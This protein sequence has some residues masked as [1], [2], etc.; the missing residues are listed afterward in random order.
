MKLGILRQP[1]IADVLQAGASCRPGRHVAVE[2]EF[3]AHLDIAEHKMVTRD[4]C[5]DAMPQFGIMQKRVACEGPS[6][7]SYL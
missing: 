5:D 2:Q 3:D 7:V 4:E 1:M 6:N